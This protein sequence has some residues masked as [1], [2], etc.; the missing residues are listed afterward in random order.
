MFRYI[1][2]FYRIF[3]VNSTKKG[4]FVCWNSSI[5]NNSTFEGMN[6]IHKHT[7]FSGYMG[8]GSYIGS[9]SSLCAKIGRF[10]SISNNVVCNFGVHPYKEPFVSTSPCFCVTNSNRRQNGGTF[11]TY[12]IFEQ[13]R[14]VD[15]EKKYAIEIGNDVWIGEG[16]FIVGGVRIADGAMVLARATVTK[17]VPPYAIVG[18]TPAR[19]MGFRYDEKTIKWLLEIKW[20][21]NPTEWFKKNWKLMCDMEKLK[22]YYNRVD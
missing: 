16:V 3:Q 7:C 13:F 10:C 12:D 11:A 21:N 4:I 1:K 22:E 15:S 5:G 6:K 18:G 19:V 2:C 20:W 14:F 8:Y 9:N 17:D